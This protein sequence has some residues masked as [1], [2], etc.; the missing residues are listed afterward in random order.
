MDE[1]IGILGSGV[2]GKAL[3][4]GFSR[5]GHS[6]KIGTRDPSK[7][8]DFIQ[9]K[10][11]VSIGS[12]EETAKFGDIIVMAVKGTEIESAMELA[13]EENFSEKV[14]IDT[15][16]PLVVEDNHPTMEIG[17]PESNG[18]TMQ[19]KLPETMVVKAF[20]TIPSHYMCAP[21]LE[22]G[23]P[24]FFYCG[25][26]ENAKEIVKDFAQQWGWKH[27]VDIGNIEESYLLEALAMIYIL[28]GFKN[29]H[30]NHAFKLLRK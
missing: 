28:Y 4:E 2:V 30:W 15:T 12:F 29:N 7:L 3:A 5:L 25:D 18:K 27:F 9:G 26:D 24:D 13:G 14:V 6:V 19:D 8:Q 17:Y 1:K 11:N 22:E 21:K 10:E 23:E 16:N 20:N